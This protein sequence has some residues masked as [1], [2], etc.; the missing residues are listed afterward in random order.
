MKLFPYRYHF[1]ITS[2]GTT[3]I[4]N[5]SFTYIKVQ[6]DYQILIKL[7]TGNVCYKEPG[8][9]TDMKKLVS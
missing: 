9:T 8:N 3:A 1:Q 2:V 5:L 6:I 7:R 4:F